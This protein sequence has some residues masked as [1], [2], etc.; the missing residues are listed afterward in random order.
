VRVFFLFENPTSKSQSLSFL[1]WDGTAKTR[2]PLSGG[3]DGEKFVHFYGD[4]KGKKLAKIKSGTI[5]TNNGAT[6]FSEEN[7]RELANLK[8][9]SKGQ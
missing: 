2:H 1:K 9:T 5:M 8:G 7:P 4:W 3:G 6:F